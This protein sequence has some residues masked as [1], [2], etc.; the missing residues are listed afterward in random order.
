MKKILRYT[1]LLLMAIAMCMSL[2]MSYPTLKGESISFVSSY[3]DKDVDIKGTYYESQNGYVVVVCPG[4][5][6]DRT[7]WRPVADMFKKDGYGVLLFDYSGQGASSGMIGFDNA[8][9]DD[10][11]CQID[12]AIQYVHKTYDVEYQKIILLG[13]SMGG[14][15]ILRLLYDYNNPA[16]VTKLTKK[17]IPLA[18]LLS[19][20]VNYNYNAQAS[21]FAGTSDESEYPWKDYS[22]KDTGNTKICLFGSYSDDIVSAEDIVKISER[23]GAEPV[24][25]RGVLH[26]YMMYSPKFLKLIKKSV[27]DFTGIKA[28]YNTSVASLNYVI[29]VLSLLGLN[30]FIKGNT[31]TVN[32][33]YNGITDKKKFVISKLLLWIPGMIVAV[34]VCS[35]CVVLPF[36]SPVMN[37]PYMN[38]ICG[39]GIVM[40]LSYRFKWV[41]GVNIIKEKTETEFNLKSIL[42]TVFVFIYVIIILRTNM[43]RLVP[44][45]YRL[46][47]LLFCGILMSI[48][49]YI[50]SC[51][52][53]MI[54]D[55]KLLFIYNI[56]QYIPLFLLVGFYLVL[57]SYSG[58]IGQIQNMIFMYMV[59]VP[60]GDYI[61]SKTNNRLLSALASSMLFQL[62]MITS[63][64]LIAIF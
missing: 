29:W 56:I 17:D 16:A 7:K 63:A 2:Y 39:Y 9:T 55:G 15:A 25:E 46:F 43:Y 35:L 61:R 1:G 49:Y 8:K 19:P 37:L 12:D 28:T 10:I 18:V 51:E 62:F 32:N 50:S 20:E 24:I 47:W 59:C 58:M 4:Y 33:I 41:K 11:P 31:V 53:D 60:L 21:L 3:K 48:G 6:C 45:N 54:D 5:S 44:L 64:A 34:L 57:K 14:R 38:F 27:E 36:G 22:K 40:A 42:L 30:L 23:T 26:S 52:R 13:H